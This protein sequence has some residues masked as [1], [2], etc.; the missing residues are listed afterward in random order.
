MPRTKAKVQT[1]TNTQLGVA[2]LAAF[3]AGGLAFAA[4]PAQQIRAPKCG[5]NPSKVVNV[6][7]GC[8]RGQYS[9][10]DFACHDGT[11]VQH[12]PGV[13]TSIAELQAVARNACA[14]KCSGA[15]RIAT[16]TL[17]IAIDSD[18]LA[19]EQFHLAGGIV[20]MGR[21]AVTAGRAEPVQLRDLSLSLE[22]EGN[23]VENIGDSLRNLVFTLSLYSDPQMGNDG[24]ISSFQIGNT[25]QASD[26]NFTVPAGTT[27]Y[28]YIGAV[29]RN[30][31]DTSPLIGEK[32]F[33]LKL[34]DENNLGVNRAIGVNSAANILPALNIE[35]QTPS[36]SIVPIRISH[37][38]SDFRGGQLVGGNQ[39]LFSFG[40]TAD[41]R[42]NSNL[43]NDPMELKLE[44][45]KMNL[46]T[47][48]PAENLS[49]LQL[50]R[51]D[52]RNCIDLLTEATATS[53]FAL[54]TA[55][56]QQDIIMNAFNNEDDQLVDGGETVR[57]EVRGTV[58]P[59]ESSFIQM[60]LV[61][62]NNE[63]MVYS[64]DQDA[65][66]N[67]EATFTN[68]HLDNRAIRDYPNLIGE[69][70]TN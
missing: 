6:L 56:D 19:P 33:R 68:I 23:N 27:Q 54:Y 34:R 20:P 61:D 58:R 37:V 15:P 39:A 26:I 63:G 22:T 64:F 40:V 36:I 43:F 66:G 51:V 25:M 2:V 45:L 12:R 24:R 60:R 48:L 49:G 28:L 62:L 21:I 53:T 10:I 69:A 8:P 30:F 9:G 13:C 52:S 29:T 1:V 47:N 65:D 42:E 3:M 38:S 11:R 17:S 5:V 7:Q 18:Y 50:C 55:G 4:A 32:T 14:N 46:I 31:D 16:G 44:K 35:S 57:F 70:L 67:Y 59:I 41:R